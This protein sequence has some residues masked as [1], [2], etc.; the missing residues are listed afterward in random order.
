MLI[1][2][3]VVPFK[4]YHRKD[5]L[6]MNLKTILS[7][8][9]KLFVAS[10]ILFVL[11]FKTFDITI[12]KGFSMNNTI[13][14]EDVVLLDMYTYQDKLP[15]YEDVVIIKRNYSNIDNSSKSKYLIKRIIGL[16][17]DKDVYKRQTGH[18]LCACKF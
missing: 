3:I 11:F 16:P 5:V 1:I 8:L 4:L 10:L 13:D 18:I 2:S 15:D 12:V 6:I 7:S 9:I 17:H 14:N